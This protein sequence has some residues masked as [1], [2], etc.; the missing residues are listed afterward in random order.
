M[1]SIPPFWYHKINAG[2]LGGLPGLERCTAVS[3]FETQRSLYN[4]FVIHFWDD[5]QE[6]LF[7]CW[8]EFLADTEVYWLRFGC[9]IVVLLFFINTVLGKLFCKRESTFF[10]WKGFMNLDAFGR[11]M[12]GVQRARGP[13]RHRLR[14]QVPQVRQRWPSERDSCGVWRIIL[15]RLCTVQCTYIVTT[16][17]EFFKLLSSVADPWHFG[18]DLDPRIH[19]SD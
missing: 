10:K 15:A 3:K 8:T 18:V 4:N 5:N 17:P 11:Q 1:F 16:E 9:Q 19:A 6:R 13:G 7:W 12:G 2:Y 14:I